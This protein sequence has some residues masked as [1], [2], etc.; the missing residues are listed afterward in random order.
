[1]NIPRHLLAL[2]WL[3][4]WCLVGTGAAPAQ[5]QTQPANVARSVSGQFVVLT[6][7]NSAGS[8]N[9]AVGPIQDGKLLQLEPAF[10]AVSGERV[11]QALAEELGAGGVWSGK[12]YISLQRAKSTDDQILLTSERFR[13]GWNYRLD[14]PN[15][16][17]P[18]R[19]VRALVQALLLEQANRSTQQRAAE[20]PLWL[21]EGL[22]QQILA[23]RGSLV[24]L[25]PPQMQVN[26]LNVQPKQLDTRR[27]E[28]ATL[29]RR[30][31]GTRAALSIDELSWPKDNQLDGPEGEIYRLSAQW[32]VAE[33][34]RLPEG[35]T[36]LQAMLRESANC[37]NWQTAFFRAF[38]R[39]FE[40]PLDV[41]KWWA[42]A[43]VHADGT[44]SGKAWSSSESWVKLDELLQV[45]AEVRRVKTE[46][47]Q[48]T[49][50]PLAAV[51]RDWDFARQ[52]PIVR[53]KIIELA[54][55]RQMVAEDFLGLV[56]EYRAVLSGYVSQREAAGINLTAGKVNTPTA[57]SVTRET[58]RQLT[59]LEQQRLRA[60]PVAAANATA[61]VNATESPTP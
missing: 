2:R 55:A 23:T 33:L 29:A 11:K 52:L 31:L 54:L 56:D 46:L 24:L 10:A 5:F 9:H 19:Y 8:R 43:T 14:V 44:E 26:R 32:F 45:P 59:R 21:S 30:A 16:V 28:A 3:A 15:P 40:R 4:V 6:A 37:L 17:E 58:L 60:K 51:I 49:L 41:E 27:T 25:A 18:T 36:K 13:D 53:A 50:V 39:D 22:L 61:V 12:I 35:R 7:R 34:L 48:A 38:G 57:R 42:L 1:M 47:P 20:I